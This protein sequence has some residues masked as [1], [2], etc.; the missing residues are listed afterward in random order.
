MEAIEQDQVAHYNIS[1]K[2][3]AEYRSLLQREE[4]REPAYHAYQVMSR[5]VQLIKEGGLLSHAHEQFHRYAYQGFP[6]VN[7]QNELVSALTRQQFYTFL[8]DA[9]KPIKA[10]TRSIRECFIHPNTKVYAADPVTDVRRIASLLVEKKLNSLPVLEETGR[11]VGI[12][13]RTDILRCVVSDPPLS[14]WC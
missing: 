8:L 9:K 4:H 3:V 12:V 6:V 7:D 13:S 10:D 5:G 11:I 14:L 1:K 2:S